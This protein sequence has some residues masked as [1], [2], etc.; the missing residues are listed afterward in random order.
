MDEVPTPQ[1]V[2]TTKAPAVPKMS[3]LGAIFLGTKR[4][5]GD[6]DQDF[7]GKLQYVRIFVCSDMW[8]G[9]D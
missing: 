1:T 2:M 3:L 6:K 4:C 9:V 7:G 8:T 5:F